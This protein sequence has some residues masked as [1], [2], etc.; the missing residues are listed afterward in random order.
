MKPDRAIYTAAAELAGCR[1]EEV[2]F[3]DDLPENVVGARAAGFDAEVFT[4]VR[5]LVGDLRRR[6]VRFNY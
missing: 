2:F 6:G 3:V 5:T 1:P 4:D